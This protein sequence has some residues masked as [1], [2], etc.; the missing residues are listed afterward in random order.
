MSETEPSTPT[1]RSPGRAAAAGAA[2]L[3]QRVRGAL[4]PR[5]QQAWLNFRVWAPF[6]LNPADR[7]RQIRYWARESQEGTTWV[8]VLPQQCWSCGSTE[9]LRSREYRRTVRGFEYPLMVIA[10]TAGAALF[11]LFLSWLFGSSALFW[12]A[13][14]AVVGGVATIFLKSWEED[15]RLLISTCPEHADGLHCPD[16]VLD[17]GELFIYAPTHRLAEMAMDELKAARRQAA[18][19]LGKP[20]GGGRTLT[21][22]VG[23]PESSGRPGGPANAPRYG[24]HVPDLPPIKLAGEEDEPAGDDG[25]PSG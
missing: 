10:M 4:R 16:M 17:Q 11:L 7:A 15:V 9:A 8:I 21:M 25:P 23:T 20:D 22:G 14:L 24:P 1:E 13:L 5:L 6:F 18:S 12:I 19:T 3:F 2:T